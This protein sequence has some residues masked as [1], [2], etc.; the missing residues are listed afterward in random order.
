[1]Q[2]YK[3]KII[4]TLSSWFLFQHHLPSS[5]PTNFL[6][7]QNEGNIYLYIMLQINLSKAKKTIRQKD[8]SKV[9]DQSEWSKGVQ[10]GDSN[11]EEMMSTPPLDGQGKDRVVPWSSKLHRDFFFLLIQTQI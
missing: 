6:P 5:S 4:S 2:R 3:K 8:Y 11:P 1:M 10:A 7:L 9:S